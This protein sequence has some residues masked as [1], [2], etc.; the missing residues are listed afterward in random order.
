VAE[1]ENT[2]A[3]TQPSRNA[4][5]GISRK[6]EARSVTGLNADQIAEI[7][8]KAKTA[9]YH[10]IGTAS[11]IKRVVTK[12]GETIGLLGQF[13]AVNAETG[14]VFY[15]GTAYLPPFVAYQMAAECS[16]AEA[17]VEFAL[18]IGV[19]PAA[20]RFGY[21]YYA[22][23]HMDPKADERLQT[24]AK[25]LPPPRKQIAQSKK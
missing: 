9:L 20:N 24:L 4:P 16:K 17:P 5:T 14:E 10:V 1:N 22:E 21:E 18:T 13:Q 2:N 25:L 11:D 23:T 6:I 15:S 7:G 8:R 12:H 19:Q 3:E